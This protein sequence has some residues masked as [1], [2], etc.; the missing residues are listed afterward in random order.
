MTASSIAIDAATN[1]V[2][3]PS[4][5]QIAPIVSLKS[6]T[7]AKGKAGSIPRRAK[8]PAANAVTVVVAWVP[9]ERIASARQR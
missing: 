6:T 1:R 4:I 5:R 3:N 8:L 2:N 9:L 7:Y